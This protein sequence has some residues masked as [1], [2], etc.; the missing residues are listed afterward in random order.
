MAITSHER[1]F[2]I[3][4]LDGLVQAYA[5]EEANNTF[6]QG[7]FMAGRKLEPDGDSVEWDEVQMH[8]HL[9]PVVGR[10]APFQILEDTTKVARNSACAHVKIM[11]RIPAAKLYNERA[12]GSLTANASQVVALEIRD[13]VKT[14]NSVK[15][16]MAV[17]TLAGTLTVNST[18]I[19]GTTVPFTLT[20]SPNTYTASTTWATVTTDIPGTEL[21]ALKQDFYQ[22]SGLQPR[23]AIIGGTIQA[24]IAK[25]DYVM[26]ML[27]FSQGE[28][29]AKSA[30][31]MFGQ[32]L[33]GFQLG[34]LDWKVN[35]AGYV[36]QGGSFTRFMPATDKGFLL[37]GPEDLPDVLGWAEGYGFVPAGTE[38]GSVDSAASLA[39][40]APSRGF[41]SY[42]K[43]AGNPATDV[44]LCIGWV[45]LP[46][47]LFPSG[48]C[49]FD[50]VP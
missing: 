4:T 7:L 24:S 13:A 38:Y 9:A 5:K 16:Y 29:L 50:T 32:A 40:K 35:E 10:D 44:E 2:G 11:K 3:R 28:N 21:A 42:A 1:V 49:V 47:L 23:T 12:P 17:N 15:E 25:N 18:N 19:P 48:V 31:A 33:G 22:T 39:V 43:R 26:Q 14:I 6:F 34:D 45:G 37:P 41:Y 8:R 30:S 46:I 20:Y 36:P 27:Q